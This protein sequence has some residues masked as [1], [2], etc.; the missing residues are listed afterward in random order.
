MIINH[1]FNFRSFTLAASL[2]TSLGFVTHAT[3]QDQ[4]FFVDLNSRTVTKLGSLFGESTVATGI[5]NAGQ[6][7]G[8]SVTLG[9]SSRAFITGPDGI[10]MRELGTL[11][12]GSNHALDINNSGQVVGYSSTATEYDHAFITGPNGVGMTDLG[13]GGAGWFANSINDFGQ[14]VLTSFGRGTPQYQ[15]N[16]ITGPNGMGIILLGTLGG[17]HSTA[18]DIN[19]SGQVVGTSQTADGSFHAF[20]TGPNDMGMTDLGTLG[21]S[22]SLASAI[23]NAGQV[24]GSSETENGSIHS[25]I[26]G[27]GGTGMTELSPG[28]YTAALDIN[29]AGQV[30]GTNGVHAFITGP[31]GIG[32]TDLNSLVDLP[33]GVILGRAVGIN[34]NGQIIALATTIPEPETYALMLAGLSLIGFIA[35]ARRQKNRLGH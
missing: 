3:A 18:Y 19:N 1:C 14:V 32:I 31:N 23:N 24:I 10:G 30:V 9:G 7:V 8:Y 12:G 20:I 11:G 6:V 35:G 21:G 22:Y 33:E 4:S 15:N 34:N 28:R 13:N 2:V 25:F 16:V 17:G 27:P 29:D 26:T 5:N